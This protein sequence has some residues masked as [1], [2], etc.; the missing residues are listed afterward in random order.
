MLKNNKK[1]IYIVIIIVAFIAIATSTFLISKTISN[2]KQDNTISKAAV[3]D[4]LKSQ[5][6]EALQANNTDK[7]KNL[8][9]QAKQKYQDLD[10]KNNIVDTEAQIYLIEHSGVSN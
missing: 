3:A 5:A 6:I 9:E 7:A 1:L 8:F 2:S 4:S 10:D